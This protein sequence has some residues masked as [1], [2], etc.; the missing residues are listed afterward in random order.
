MG[1]LSY[2]VV[3]GLS[4]IVLLVLVLP[5][6][7]HKVEE[8]LEL[9]L[10][11]MGVAALT[12]VQRW[13]LHLVME[14]AKDPIKITVAVLVLGILFEFLERNFRGFMLKL[15][16]KFHLKP[17]LFIIVLLLSL[18]S[19]LITAIVA[20]IMLAEVVN[21]LGLQGKS[22]AKFVV[23]ACFAI[24]M[25]AVLT[26]IGEPLSTIVVSKL[27][28]EPHNA[29]FLFLA[30]ILGV[31]VI[32]GVVVFSFLA[33]RIDQ[34]RVHI[35]AKRG[36]KKHEFKGI[37]IRAAKVY[38]FVAAL[39]FLGAGLT[40]LAEITIFKLSDPVL[41]WVNSVS[42]ILDNATLA[43]I[44]IVPQMSLHTIKFLLMGLI[45][46]G[47]LLIPGNIPN[48]ICAS[49]LKIG[50]SEWAKIGIP[51]GIVTMAVYFALM[52]IIL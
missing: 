24:G 48:I 41:Y 47:G 37:A 6:A 27:K 20:A 10:F 44:E 3:A 51:Y 34:K 28:G 33:S 45:L 25:G 8:N 19:S 43:A 5:L 29:D 21:V 40:P 39:V 46:A 1:G 9:F 36:Y 22:K 23:L 17:T 11:I 13:D 38:F 32:P 4:L 2:Y 31:W 30:R 42:A 35:E 7:V 50:S 12:I 15:T 16:R 49:K 14:A 18:A 52:M 26:P